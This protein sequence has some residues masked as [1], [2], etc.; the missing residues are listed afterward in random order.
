MNS[1]IALAAELI[2]QAARP[3]LGRA[4]N[5]QAA[6]RIDQALAN[7][8]R[9]SAQLLQEPLLDR[10]R[11]RIEE[12]AVDGL[13]YGA[14]M[15]LLEL[16]Q[17]YSAPLD[18]ELLQLLQRRSCSHED[19]LRMR[20]LVGRDRSVPDEIT[21]AS[22]DESRSPEGFPTRWFESEV[23]AAANGRA[24]P[25]ELMR[26]MLQIGT[27]VTIEALRRLLAGEFRETLVAELRE[28]FGRDTIEPEQRNFWSRL[29]EVDL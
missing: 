29:L 2:E 16:R 8:Q 28:F 15:W 4:A 7:D 24:D 20:R 23:T 14:W 13:S 18:E 25:F 5:E 22:P 3:E 1:L 17:T 12:W 26:D 10:E 11:D 19:R 9:L 27:P 21:A 6:A